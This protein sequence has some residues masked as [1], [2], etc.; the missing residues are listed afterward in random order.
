MSLYVLRPHPGCNRL[1][2]VDKNRTKARGGTPT[3]VAIRVLLPPLSGIA[4]VDNAARRSGAMRGLRLPPDMEEMHRPVAT[5]DLQ[6]LRGR[7]RSTHLH[8][9]LA[10]GGDSTQASRD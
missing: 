10:R 6:T 9:G 2:T 4:P 3:S 1:A 7:N 8:L 5:T